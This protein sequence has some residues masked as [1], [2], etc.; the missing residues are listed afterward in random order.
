M[1]IATN[2]AAGRPWNEDL[3][4]AIAIGATTGMIDAFTDHYGDMLVDRAMTPRPVR[5]AVDEDSGPLRPVQEQRGEP[6][7][8]LMHEGD[9]DLS[10]A[11]KRLDPEDQRL[12]KART[13]EELRADGTELSRKT[14]DRLERE[15]IFPVYLK[16]EQFNQVYLRR[17]PGAKDVDSVLTFTTGNENI[18]LRTEGRTFEQLVLAT[19]HE[20]THVDTNWSG[21]LP[22]MA[23][24][25]NEF[26][27]YNAELEFARSKGWLQH[28]PENRQTVQGITQ[29]VKDNYPWQKV[30]GGTA[31]AKQK[32]AYE[33]MPVDRLRY[34][35]EACSPGGGI[36]DEGV[37][38]GEY[39]IEGNVEL[40]T[41]PSY[42]LL[43]VKIFKAESY[44]H[45]WEPM[46][47]TFTR[48]DGTTVTYSGDPK[49]LEIGQL[50]TLDNRRLLTYRKAGR[51]DIPFVWA[52]REDVW[53]N[54]FEMSTKDYGHTIEVRP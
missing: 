38:V 44:M 36:Y 5:G 24:F 12:L 28:I 7:T 22:G 33:R 46:S 39:T 1:K 41:D 16:D 23:V 53:D 51:T 37:Q 20:G 34:T 11:I 3:G 13:I 14:A 9:D 2:V 43:P 50:Y 35:Q 21:R 25:D 52:S 8:R 6:N 27:S 48:P 29:Y 31:L 32:R 54:R 17:N 4:Q 40:L 45:E 49:N 10:Q 18:Y 42:D 47:K 26:K 15:A 30:Y 19:L